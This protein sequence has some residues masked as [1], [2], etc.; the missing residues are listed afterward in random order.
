MS[1]RIWAPLLI[2][3]MVIAVVPRKWGWRY[4]W[5]VAMDTLAFSSV[6]ILPLCAGIAAMESGRL[7]CAR[8]LIL[9]SSKATTA[10]IRVVFG[11]WAAA[12]LAVLTSAALIGACVLWSTGF[13]PPRPGDFTPLAPMVVA[14]LAACALGALIGWAWRSRVAPASVALGVF[15]TIMT[16]YVV[17]SG[18]FADY[19]SIGGTPSS[20]LGYQPHVPYHS[21][22]CLFYGA[23]ALVLLSGIALLSAPRTPRALRA[24]GAMTGCAAV[25]LVLAAMT[26]PGYAEGF[27]MKGG[28]EEADLVCSGQA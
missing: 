22:L 9:V 13:L 27:I 1:V 21:W 14:E 15:V 17:D 18:R 28:G 19:V 16:G 3:I 8:D 2:L 11:V 7:A 20:L 5:P 26:I 24:R 12:C 23:L 10:I 25:V 6:F 4:E